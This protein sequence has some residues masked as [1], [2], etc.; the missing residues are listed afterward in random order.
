ML[1]C[2]TASQMRSNAPWL[3][4]DHTSTVWCV[5][6]HS[7]LQRMGAQFKLLGTVLSKVQKYFR[8]QDQ[9]NSWVVSWN[10]ISVWAYWLA[11]FRSSPPFTLSKHTLRSLL[12]FSLNCAAR[13]A[14]W[15]YCI[16]KLQV[17]TFRFFDF[18]TWWNQNA[19]RI[20]IFH[21]HFS[22]LCCTCIAQILLLLHTLQED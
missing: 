4:C 21:F 7:L 16:A 22:S 3:W 11:L 1:V 6:S 19:K 18:P 20:A 13:I 9:H 12:G 17:T 8:W 5:L 10:A 15:S 14:D 2:L